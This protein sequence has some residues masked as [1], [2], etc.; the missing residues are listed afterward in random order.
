MVEFPQRQSPPQPNDL[1]SRFEGLTTEILSESLKAGA[2]A[3]RA[4]TANHPKTSAGFYFYSEVVRVLRDL[5]SVY[6]W[7][8][9][10]DANIE[11]VVD[12]PG[13]QRIFVLA[14]DAETGLPGGNPRSRHRRGSYG[15]HAIDRNQ[16]VLDMSDL[17]EVVT[18]S[19]ED[20]IPTW[21]LLHHFDVRTQRIQSE[22]S[23]PVKMLDDGRV[24]GWSERIVLPALELV[25]VK[26]PD[27]RSDAEVNVEVRRRTTG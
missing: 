4:C 18:P 24:C 19:D 9:D 10:S 17:V 22:L 20:R 11:Y 8:P 23:L 6:G 15:R 16:L 12:P 5:L 2:A 26:I 1:L 7:K 13:D 21:A 25:S 3:Y 27:R 14:G